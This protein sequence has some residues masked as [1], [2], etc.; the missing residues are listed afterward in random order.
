MFEVETLVAGILFL[1]SNTIKVFE[2]NFETRRFYENLFHGTRIFSN[3]TTK[4]YTDKIMHESNDIHKRF[5][6]NQDVILT[7]TYFS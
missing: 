7:T 5:T 1:F 4:F 2:Q 6:I 3:F